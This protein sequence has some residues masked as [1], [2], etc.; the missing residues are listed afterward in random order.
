VAA[1]RSIMAHAGN[2]TGVCSAQVLSMAR[3]TPLT[4][5]AA[6]QCAVPVLPG[7]AQAGQHHVRH[8]HNTEVALK[9]PLSRLSS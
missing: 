6:A 5:A 8:G 2:T 1:G 9:P 4:A 7:G 3:W